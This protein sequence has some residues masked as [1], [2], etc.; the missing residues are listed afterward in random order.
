MTGKELQNKDKIQHLCERVCSS[1]S[2]QASCVPK[3][4]PAE[5]HMGVSPNKEPNH[6]NEPV[7]TSSRAHQP[8]FFS[9]FSFPNPVEI[10]CVDTDLKMSQIMR[11]ESKVR[12]FMD[13]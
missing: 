1:E 8:R 3:D 10:K 12:V 6:G 7:H 13:V 4:I 9:F 2:A 11:F 5:G